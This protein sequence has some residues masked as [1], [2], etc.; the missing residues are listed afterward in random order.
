MNLQDHKEGYMGGFRMRKQ[1][2]DIIILKSQKIKEIKKSA[3]TKKN[4]KY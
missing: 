1:K 2:K 3:F 4:R